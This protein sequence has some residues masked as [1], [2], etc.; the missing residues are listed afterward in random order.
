[1]NKTATIEVRVTEEFK[2]LL[3][4]K[5]KA[6]GEKPADFIRETLKDRVMN[7]RKAK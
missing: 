2:R 5:A 3:L 7:G 1:M 6:V 4:L